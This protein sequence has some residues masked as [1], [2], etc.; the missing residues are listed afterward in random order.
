MPENQYEENTIQRNDSAE[1]K[2]WFFRM[3]LFLYDGFV[4][5]FAFF[6]AIIIRFYVNSVFY[7]SGAK[8]MDMFWRYAPVYTAGSLIIFLLFRLYSGVWR[9]VGVNDVRKLILANLCTCVFQIAG[10]LVVVGRMPISYYGM[11]A[12]IQLFMMSLPRVAPRF[13]IESFS[14]TAP[15]GG[16]RSTTLSMMIVGVGENA[17]IIQKAANKDK[18]S[19]F[20]P[21][22]IADCSGGD[23]R[24]TFNG[25]PIVSGKNGIENAVNKYGIKCIIIAD[26]H[27]PEN[28]YDSI[29]DICDKYDI[30]L[31]NFSMKA[32]H[33]GEGIKLQDILSLINGEICIV[34]EGHDDF[35]SDIDTVLEKYRYNYRVEGISSGEDSVRIHVSRIRA[36][37][38]SPDDD[39]VKKYKDENGGEVSFFV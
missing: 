20:R 28:I 25:L 37:Q 31:R 23:S 32:E 5:N 18:S 3:V 35:R 15:A 27:L 6:M 34:E 14:A 10:S 26:D 33:S 38:I 11:G 1:L 2:K 9:Y 19:L 21:V 17:R 7:D 4:V 39:W 12:F 22:C 29:H 13:I 16:Q 24:G 36:A 8:Y 30:E